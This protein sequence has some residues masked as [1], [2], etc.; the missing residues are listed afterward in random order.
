MDQWVEQKI[1]TKDDKKE[2]QKFEAHQKMPN[3]D[4]GETM[5]K[6]KYKQR[7][8]RPSAFSLLRIKGD[9]SPINGRMEEEIKMR[10][11]Q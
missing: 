5:N 10:Q 4:S 9:R 3:I 11:S 8:K 7:L 2:I 6:Y 1:K